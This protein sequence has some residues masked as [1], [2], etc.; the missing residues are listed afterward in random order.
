MRPLRPVAAALTTCALLGAP[1]ATAADP[2][3]FVADGGG[4]RSVL[5]Y[6]QGETADVSE[7]AAHVA[8]GA[9]PASFTS[10]AG[11]YNAGVASADPATTFKDASFRPERP[12]DVVTVP[13]EGVRIARDATYAVPRIYGTTRGDVMYGA[14][15]AAAQDRLFLMD[16]LRRT[17]QGRL[18]GLLGASA[19]AGDSAALGTLDLSPDELTREVQDL[20]RTNGA[21]ARLTLLP[22]RRGDVPPPERVAPVPKRYHALA[23]AHEAHPGT[24]LGYGAL[25][26]AATA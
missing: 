13:R 6:G 10:Q 16:V 15:Y 20:P 18:S 17:A 4:F 3:A 2:P 25:A 23:A 11:L 1:L 22:P 26:R 5:A 7:V 21:E 19:A 12:D 8:T 14:G 24:G 9:V